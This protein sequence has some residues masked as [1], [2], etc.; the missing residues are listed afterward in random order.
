MM[1]SR[2]DDLVCPQRKQK[3]IL[4]RIVVEAGQNHLRSSDQTHASHLYE[5]WRCR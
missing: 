4:T 2:I 3:H 1:T 5:R